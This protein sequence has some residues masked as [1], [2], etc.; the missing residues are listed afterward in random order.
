MGYSEVRHRPDMGSAQNRK[1][2]ERA[3]DLADWMCEILD[4]YSKIHRHDVTDEYGREPL[5]TSGPR[6][7]SPDGGAK[8]SRNISRSTCQF[9][10][11]YF[12][13]NRWKMYCVCHGYWDV[14]FKTKIDKFMI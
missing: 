9:N 3:V 2:A 7:R 14:V 4:E 10:W 11:L 8:N 1:A 6:S 12:P 13:V 5:L